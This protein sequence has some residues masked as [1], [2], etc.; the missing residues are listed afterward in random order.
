MRS[1]ALEPPKHFEYLWKEAI[2]PSIQVCLSE[3]SEDFYKLAS[4]NCQ[5]LR[6]YKANLENVYKKKREWLKRSYLPQNPE[7]YLDFHKLG[8]IVCR[9]IIG[10]KPVK[11]DIS[12]VEKLILHQ[13]Q[14]QTSH[15]AQIDWFIKNVYVNYRIALLSAVGLVYANLVHWALTKKEQCTD[16]GLVEVYNEFM[17]RAVQQ[18]TLCP[19]VSSQSHENFEDSMVIALMKSDL[20]QRDFDYLG[21]ATNLYQWEYFTKLKIFCEILENSNYTL[22]DIDL[23]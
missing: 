15:T 1:P 17:N 21:F 14:R 2:Y 11:Y 5:D 9:S 12:A 7:P 18:G 13:E 4:V 20:L 19:Y 22:S 3:M 8:A 6:S 10:L 23:S 16:D